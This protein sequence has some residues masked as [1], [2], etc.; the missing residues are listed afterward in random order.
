M[1][2]ID[3]KV[4]DKDLLGKF[5]QLKTNVQGRTI[6]SGLRKVGRIIINKAKRNFKQIRKNKSKTNYSTMNQSFRIES[7]KNRKK[8]GIGLK[9]GVKNYKYGW[10]EY[11]T[12][13]RS[14]SI[15]KRK[16]FFS[17]KTT[18]V[19]KTGRIKPQYF[20]EKAVKDTTPQA[21]QMIKDNVIKSIERVVKKNNL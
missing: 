8:W 16:N 9:V 6:E 5:E 2:D 11:G 1:L 10:I 19:H 20:F 15:S 13:D 7:L 14:Y 4:I 12:Q 21:E 3:F 17:K 18:T